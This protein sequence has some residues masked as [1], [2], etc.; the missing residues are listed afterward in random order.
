[1]SVMPLLQHTGG[2]QSASS[3]VGLDFHLVSDRISYGLPLCVA[4]QLTHKLQKILLALF[5]ISL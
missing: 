5:P 3:G 2:S 4:G 1:M